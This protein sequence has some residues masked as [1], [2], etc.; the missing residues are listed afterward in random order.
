L[1]T[2]AGLGLTNFTYNPL[3]ET[4]FKKTLNHQLACPGDNPPHSHYSHAELV[5]ASIHLC[6]PHPHHTVM[7]NL[8]LLL[9]ALHIFPF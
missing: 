9:A 5:S 7:L 2:E 3:E 8:F 1:K 6:L 4:F